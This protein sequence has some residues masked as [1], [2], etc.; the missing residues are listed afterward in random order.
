MSFRPFLNFGS[1]IS[2]T[3]LT[4]Q[5]GTM[6]RSSTLRPGNIALASD[7]CRF[8][9]SCTEYSMPQTV[10]VT[11]IS[12]AVQAEGPT[13]LLSGKVRVTSYEGT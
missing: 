8:G 3:R 2:F 10:V 1:G 4:W 9:H 7:L 13:H 11:G 12:I 6:S 5:V